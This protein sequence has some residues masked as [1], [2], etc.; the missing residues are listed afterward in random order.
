MLRCYYIT[1]GFYVDFSESFDNWCLIEL[2]FFK[3]GFDQNFWELS[4]MQYAKDHFMRLEIET[5]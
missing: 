3:V 2:P 5:K 4:H 1:S